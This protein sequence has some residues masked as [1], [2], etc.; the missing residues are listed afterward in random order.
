MLQRASTPRSYGAPMLSRRWSR[1][2]RSRPGPWFRRSAAADYA[3]CARLLEPLASEVARIGGSGAQREI[4]EDTLL[5]AL[6]R[7]GETGKARDML[8]R[9]LSRR[10][11]PRD[12]VWRDR[13]AR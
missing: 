9:R 4:I 10:P 1:P 3:G 2:G 8:D 7:G 12:A 11:S 5:V 13:F 6:M